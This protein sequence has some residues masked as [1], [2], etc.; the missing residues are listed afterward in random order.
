MSK[1][2]LEMLMKSLKFRVCVC[3][4]VRACVHA[5]VCGWAWHILR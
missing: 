3:V 5:C 4:C 1:T 2:G